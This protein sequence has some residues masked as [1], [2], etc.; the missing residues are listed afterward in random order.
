MHIDT[1]FSS[2]NSEARLHLQV[3]LTAVV[4][5]DGMSLSV[6]CCCG[7]ESGVSGGVSGQVLFKYR[8]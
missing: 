8:S 2:E 6:V 4:S 1:L 7:T 3:F 5:P